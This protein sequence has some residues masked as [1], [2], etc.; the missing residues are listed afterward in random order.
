MD[1]VH[2]SI[3]EPAVF[4]VTLE[5]HHD[6][7]RSYVVTVTNEVIQTYFSGPGWTTLLNEH[8][9]LQYGDK[10]KILLDHHHCTIYFRYPFPD[11]SD[12]GEE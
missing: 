2:R 5:S 3:N 1:H 8:N 7:L 4:E 11:S 6:P 10:F 9:W 12:E